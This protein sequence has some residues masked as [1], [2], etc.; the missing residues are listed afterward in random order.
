MDYPGK[1]GNA[2]ENAGVQFAGRENGRFFLHWPDDF[3]LGQEISDQ[4]AIYW[5]PAP[6]WRVLLLVAGLSLIVLWN[7][8]A[9]LLGAGRLS[10]DGLLSGERGRRGRRAPRRVP[11][12]AQAAPARSGAVAGPQRA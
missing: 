9:R 7:A 6:A 12:A 5:T 2:I 3:Q 1:Q 10:G 8:F 4:L 11:G